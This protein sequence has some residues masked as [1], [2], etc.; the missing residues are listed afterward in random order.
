MRRHIS[1]LLLLVLLGVSLAGAG[2][3]PGRE[4]VPKWSGEPGIRLLVEWEGR[5]PVPPWVS[6]L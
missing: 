1:L 3:D 4:T 5:L 6:T 2:R